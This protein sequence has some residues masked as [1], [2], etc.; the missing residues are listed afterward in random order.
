MSKDGNFLTQ[1]LP[2]MK[3]LQTAEMTT[4]DVKYAQTLVDETA[5][6]FKRTDSNF[7]RGSH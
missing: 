7:E 3:L 5:A 2:L 6:M 1:N 4:K